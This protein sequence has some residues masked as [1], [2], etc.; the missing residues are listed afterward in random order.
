MGLIE[1]FPG[2]A[3]FQDSSAR[4]TRS[5][6]ADSL[7]PCQERLGAITSSMTIG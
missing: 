1:R 2:R 6:T 4:W 3:A 5:A 7:I